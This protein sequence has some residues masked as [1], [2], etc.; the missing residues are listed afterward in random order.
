[1]PSLLA[2][3]GVF[4]GAVGLDGGSGGLTGGLQIVCFSADLVLVRPS[5]SPEKKKTDLQLYIT[6]DNKLKEIKFVK[7]KMK[8]CD[9]F[10]VRKRALTF[11][12][13]LII[14][15]TKHP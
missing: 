13:I 11:T 15:Y 5:E 12:T 6:A 10:R 3:V 4:C 2:A 9:G 14:S 1:M 7:D 8:D